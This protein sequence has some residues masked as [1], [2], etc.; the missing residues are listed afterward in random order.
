MTR[1]H[2][3]ITLYKFWQSIQ[4]QNAPFSTVFSLPLVHYT[5]S[6]LLLASRSLMSA[7]CRAAQASS[8]CIWI[9]YGPPSDASLSVWHVCRTKREP[10]AVSS[11]RSPHKRA[12]HAVSESSN[13]ERRNRLNANAQTEHDVYAELQ[14]RMCYLFAHKVYRNGGNK[15]SLRCSE[16]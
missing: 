15:S 14:S 5:S 1:Q 6:A 11:T 4:T 3:C 8:G 13:D 16:L 10:T 12:I 2:W 7:R 9:L